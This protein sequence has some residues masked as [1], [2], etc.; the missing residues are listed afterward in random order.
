MSDLFRSISMIYKAISLSVV[1][2]YL[3]I[4]N[5]SIKILL[6][7]NKGVENPFILYINVT[8]HIT[9]FKKPT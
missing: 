1:L 2:N 9:N 5:P 7:I 4:N 3:K 6:S 8:I